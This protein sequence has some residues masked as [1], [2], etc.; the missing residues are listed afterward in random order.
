MTKTETHTEANSI[1]QGWNCCWCNKAWWSQA[2]PYGQLPATQVLDLRPGLDPGLH[3]LRLSDFSDLETD[4]VPKQH[5]LSSVATF[6]WHWAR[7]N[8]HCWVWEACKAPAWACSRLPQAM[9][10][11][12]VLTA[13]MELTTSSTPSSPNFSVQGGLWMES[14]SLSRNCFKAGQSS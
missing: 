11:K 10:R 5:I 4:S 7:V 6:A 13:D 12:W 3:P 1:C 14:A 9:L 2:D 8:K